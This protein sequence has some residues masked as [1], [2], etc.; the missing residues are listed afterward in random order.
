MRI[1]QLAPLVESVPPRTYG[2][3][4][5]V[6]SL[7][8]E[9]LVAAG[10]QVTLFASGDSRTTANLISVAPKALRLDEQIPMRRWSAY[11]LL[12]L[13]EFDKRKSDFDIVHNHMSYEALSALGRVS[14]PSLTTNHNPIKDYCA[15]L[16]LA[17]PS[18][19]FVSISKSYQQL[20]YP[21]KLNYA[22]TIYNGI[23]LEPFSKIGPSKRKFLLFIGRISK[24]K[25]TAESIEVAR[26]LGL[27]LIIAGKVDKSDQSYFE[28][29]VKVRLNEPGIDYIGEVSFVEKL[30]LYA[31]SL[32]VLYPIDFDEPF[33]LVL[34]ESMASGTPVMAFRRGSVPEI[35][36]D[37]ET[38]IIGRDIDELVSRY[39]EIEQIN[40]SSCVSHCQK[41]F[42][43]ERMVSEYLKLYQNLCQYP[44]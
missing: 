43:K 36:V 6:V 15:P 24:D 8:T 2:G 18:H 34:A 7:L 20:N 38:G 23:D 10:H 37:G 14:S 19:P 4:E 29:Y 44:K 26:R 11:S 16:Y 9:G 27:P 33:G 5:L 3:T 22:A 31:N 13:N 1:A 41:H 35:I 30:A 12:Q 40:H 39:G 42:S 28:R 21:E 25:G 32:A 17:N